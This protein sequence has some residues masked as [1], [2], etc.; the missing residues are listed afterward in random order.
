MMAVAMIITGLLVIVAK[1]YR[2]DS[3]YEMAHQID[4]FTKAIDKGLF[5][6]NID[7]QN[8]SFRFDNSNTSGNIGDDGGLYLMVSDISSNSTPNIT[9]ESVYNALIRGD[10][11]V[12]CFDSNDNNNSQC[13]G[14]ADDFK[15]MCQNNDQT[16]TLCLEKVFDKR[17]IDTYMIPTVIQ[18][19]IS[20]DPKNGDYQIIDPNYQI[21]KDLKSGSKIVAGQLVKLNSMTIDLSNNP[22]LINILQ[23]IDSR[24][25]LSKTDKNK[26]VYL[27]NNGMGHL[28]IARKGY[29]CQ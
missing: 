21:V 3:D 23:N 10:C 16:N 18:E 28:I 7:L 11:M 12:R 14:N 26:V 24:Y 29:I 6:A 19:K 20:F 25:Q 5:I 8:H 17:Y 2:I 15:G 9:F 4:E 13:G 27:L 1:I 22:N